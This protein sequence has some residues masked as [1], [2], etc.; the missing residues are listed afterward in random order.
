M[1]CKCLLCGGELK[2]NDDLFVGI[3]DIVNNLSNGKIKL[4]RN[5]GIYKEMLLDNFIP[6]YEVNKVLKNRSKLLRKFL[7]RI[8]KVKVHI[9]VNSLIDD[10]IGKGKIVCRKVD[11]IYFIK[12]KQ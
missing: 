9:Y 10:L 2:D 6:K 11:E 1:S 12:V 7:S 4:V 3:L 8:P 5:N